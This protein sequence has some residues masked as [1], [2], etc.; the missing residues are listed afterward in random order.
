M[1]ITDPET[2]FLVRPPYLPRIKFCIVKK[3][4]EILEPKWL[5]FPL[6]TKIKDFKSYLRSEGVLKFLRDFSDD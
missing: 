2:S 1:A 3:D 4:E 5:Y 6:K